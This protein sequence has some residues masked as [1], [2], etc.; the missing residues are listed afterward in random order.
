MNKQTSSLFTLF[1]SNDVLCV[2]AAKIAII[3][4]SIKCH[5]QR[6]IDFNKC[7]SMAVLLQERPLSTMFKTILFGNN[8]CR[9]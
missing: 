5:V 9:I 6:I 2:V 4:E 7:F 3:S 1:V 8:Y